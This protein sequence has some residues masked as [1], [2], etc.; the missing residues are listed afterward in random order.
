VKQKFII[1]D[2]VKLNRK[3]ILE[4]DYSPEL[5]SDFEPHYNKTLIVKEVTV[6]SGHYVYELH[7]LKYYYWYEN[8][9][10]FIDELTLKT[11]EIIKEISNNLLS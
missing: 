11:E 8:E 10:E 1:G 4:N 3:E 2:R 9:I 6:L 7:E 5:L